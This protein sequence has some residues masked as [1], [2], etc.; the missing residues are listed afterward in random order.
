MVGH[1]CYR[2]PIDEYNDSVSKSSI[3]FRHGI[4]AKFTFA[5]KFSAAEVLDYQFTES[6]SQRCFTHYYNGKRTKLASNT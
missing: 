2:S 6:E 1:K 4:V 3:V 5:A